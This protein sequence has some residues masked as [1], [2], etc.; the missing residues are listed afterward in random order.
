MRRLLPLLLLA[1]ALAGC[2]TP[3]PAPRLYVLDPVALTNPPARLPQKLT[4]GIAAAQVPEYLDRPEL[5]VRAGANEVKAVDGERW[6]ERLPATLSRVVSEN[7]TRLLGQQTQLIQA[8]RP[9]VPL[10]YE[11]YLTLT[12]LDIAAPSGEI[13]LGGYWILFDAESRKEILSGPIA[14]REAGNGPG[15]PGA[16]AG[17][18]KAIGAVSA[19]IAGAIRTLPPKN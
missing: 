4:I 1:P 16:V 3:E 9:A 12:S 17:I 5:I 15:L 6:A 8:S 10:D 18:N 19:D 2:L 13:S 14:R 7:L 11:V